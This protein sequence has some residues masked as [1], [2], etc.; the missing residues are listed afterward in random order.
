M[1]RPLLTIDQ[2]KEIFWSRVDRSGG[3]NACWPWQGFFTQGGYGKVYRYGSGRA[4]PKHTLAHRMA[5]EY[6]MDAQPPLGKLVLH[7]CDNPACCNPR[8][9]WIGTQ[10]DNLNDMV[11][12]KR[13]QWSRGT[14]RAKSPP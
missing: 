7:H 10:S 11:A 1:A 6:A 8:H 3:V 14:R 5:Y 2:Y 12:K 4:N 9:L 13:D